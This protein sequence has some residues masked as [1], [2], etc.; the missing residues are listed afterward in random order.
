M[1]AELQPRPVHQRCCLAPSDLRLAAETAG[2]LAQDF[3]LLSDPIR[4]Q[5]LDVLAERGGEVC[6]CD[7]EAAL[8][9]KQPTISHHL[10]LLRQ[11]GVVSVVRRGLWAY[12]MLDIAVIELRRA[13]LEAFLQ[14]LF[15]RPLPVSPSE[16]PHGR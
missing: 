10:R 5:I 11:A 14:S 16:D 1:F 8:P 15:A 12:Y 4:L 9:V 3:Q 7:L 2:V 13:R 6:V